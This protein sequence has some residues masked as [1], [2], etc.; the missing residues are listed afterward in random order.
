MKRYEIKSKNFFTEPIIS[1]RV[2]HLLVFVFAFLGSMTGVVL[3]SVTDWSYW[4][5][6]LVVFLMAI[7]LICLIKLVRAVWLKMKEKNGR[8]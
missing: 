5:I 4:L 2:D 7:I 6:L 8:N 3:K 1:P